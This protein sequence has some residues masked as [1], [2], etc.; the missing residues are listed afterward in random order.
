MTILASVY[1]DASVLKFLPVLV[2]MSDWHHI[3]IF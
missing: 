2:S 1:N 3:V